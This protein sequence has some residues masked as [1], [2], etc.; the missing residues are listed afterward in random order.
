MWIRE[1]IGSFGT[2]CEMHAFVSCLCKL[3]LLDV[4]TIIIYY[5]SCM[6][7]HSSPNSPG[8]ARAHFLRLKRVSLYIKRQIS[9]HTDPAII[10]Q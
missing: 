8:N 2:T 6:R 3:L 1:G 7:E 9:L 4:V 10:M 5:G